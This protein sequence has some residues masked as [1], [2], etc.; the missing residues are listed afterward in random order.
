MHIAHSSCEC[1]C[2]CGVQTPKYGWQVDT[3]FSAPHMILPAI[4]RVSA[5]DVF[6]WFFGL[7]YLFSWLMQCVRAIPVATDADVEDGDTR[8]HCSHRVAFGSQKQHKTLRCCHRLHTCP[9]L[10]HAYA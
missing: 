2:K 8:V 3:S 4:R 6:V 7:Y 9:H 5:C 10:V 1:E